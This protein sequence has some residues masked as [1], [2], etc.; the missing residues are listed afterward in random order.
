[1][2][3]MVNNLTGEIQERYGKSTYIFTYYMGSTADVDIPK[4][5]ACNTR[6]LWAKVNNME[7]GDDLISAMDNY[8]KLSSL[9]LGEGGNKDFLSIVE[10]YNDFYTGKMATIVLSP[11]YERTVNPSNVMGVVGIGSFMDALDQVLGKTAMSST[12]LN[13]FVA[14]SNAR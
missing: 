5:I 1:M 3:N 7:F 6:S 14:L 8:Y 11:V 13:R 4:K 9:V 12:M 10:T 2:I